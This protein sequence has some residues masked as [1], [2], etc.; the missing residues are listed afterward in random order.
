MLNFSR[1]YDLYVI[2][3]IILNY[4]TDFDRSEHILVLL[5]KLKYRKIILLKMQRYDLAAERVANH[6]PYTEFLY[7]SEDARIHRFAQKLVREDPAFNQGIKTF[8]YSRAELLNL[9]MQQCGRF[10]ELLQ[11]GQMTPEDTNIINFYLPNTIE[12]FTH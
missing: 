5:Q 8:D 12:I 7:N 11:Q 10:A 4:S 3:I 6:K 1:F 9:G 2:S